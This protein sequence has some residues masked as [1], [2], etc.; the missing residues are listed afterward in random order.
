MSKK[1]KKEL[2]RNLGAIG[3][4]FLLLF[5][6][7]SDI[8]PFIFENRLLGFLVYLLPYLLCGLA[9]VKN[10]LHGILNRQPFDEAL[11]MT[12][13]TFGAF[14]IGENSEAVAVMAFYQIGEWFQNFAVG[15]SRASIKSLMEI[16]PET[17]NRERADGSMEEIDPE[18]V[19]VGD[20]LVIRPGEKI[21]V[22]GRVSLGESMVNTSALTGE[23]IPREVQPGDMV[24]SGCINGEGL[25]K[26]RA[27][28]EFADSTVSKILE[29]VEEASDKKSKTENFITRFARI[30]TPLVVGVAL[31]IAVLPILGSFLYL[32]LG[33]GKNGAELSGIA[34]FLQNAAGAPGSPVFFHAWKASAYRACTFLVV[35][36]P[37]ALVISVPLAFFG[38]IGAASRNGVLVKGSN[39]LELLAQLK[40]VV[41]DKTGTLTKGVFSV[42]KILPAEGVPE[43]EVLRLS[44]A[45]E[46]F[47]THPIALSILECFH[48]TQGEKQLPVPE[49]TENISGH[50][51]IARMEG[52]AVLVGKRRLLEER[53]IPVPEIPAEEATLS[54]VARGGKYLGVLL[55]SDELKESAEEALRE[56]KKEGVSRIVM[57]SGDRREAARQMQK[58]LPLDQVYAEL[59]PQDK[60]E[61][62]EE[63]IE[64][65]SSGKGERTRG[66][67]AFLGDGINDAPVLRRADVG[68]AMGAMGSDAAIEAADVVIMD[69]DLRRIPLV[70]R[71]AKSTVRI[72]KQNIGFAIAV[73]ILILLG[74]AFGLANMWAAVFGDVG[75]A[76]LCILNS[77]RLLGKNTGKNKTE[78]M[79]RI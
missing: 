22:D 41:T 28:K 60:V 64:A 69:D 37:C 5:L 55:I 42:R 71:I 56:M 31:L 17:A 19:K 4:F 27:E 75:V 20:V 45:V 36:C 70:I 39:Y 65:L 51:I 32:L 14:L 54:Y 11:L 2:Y 1:L 49:N 67:L 57:L 18:E 43:E 8:C 10:A 47:S 16:V 13:A 46:A 62:V 52:A 63:L 61:K 68:I 29:L 77:M 59:L 3:I 7:H 72:S 26:I 25:L 79:P 6:E 34:G 23:S 15:R 24:I 9:V 35:S 21:P 44:A 40:T 33:W 30:Y 74:S 48:E 58:Q 38:G 76:T 73:K 50:G 66:Y 53:G 12:I 78:R